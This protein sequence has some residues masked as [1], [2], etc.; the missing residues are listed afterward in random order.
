MPTNIGYA[1]DDASSPLRPWPFDRPAVGREDV[2]IDIAYCGVCHSDVHQA[3]AEMGGALATNFPC[4][5]GHEIV[6]TVAEVGADVTRHAVG[7]R[8]GVGCLVYWG[9]ESQRG[10]EDEQYQQPPAVF[11]YN[12][13]DPDTG[14]VTFGGY[15][16]EIVVHEHFVLSI[17]DALDLA[18]A[19]PL[20]CAG[21]TT[22][23]PLTRWGVQDKVVGVAGLGG[24]GHLGLKLAKAL[25]ASRVVALTT[26]ADK[27]DGARA[28][29]ADDVVVMTDEDAVTDAADSLD[30]VLSTIPTAFDMNPYLSLLAANGVLATVGLLEPIGEGAID[31]GVVSLK[32]LT[33]GGSLI[34][35]LQQTQE[36]LDLCAEHG[37][38]A[39]IEL[40]AADRINEA[41]DRL[42][43]GDVRFRF[44]IDSSTLPDPS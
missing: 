34:G 22:Y 15:S 12:A 40:I 24:L 41:F 14:E 13:P 32:R 23:A 35:N 4:M 17:P 9:D 19:A 18:A 28:S 36:V 21:V 5:P 30:L 31:F 33:I 25:G 10:V 20:L 16:D 2:R 44:V 3:R 27:A 43:E 38:T 26:S 6:G 29:G 8:V 1:T 39:D 42:V 7:D 11:T 37:I